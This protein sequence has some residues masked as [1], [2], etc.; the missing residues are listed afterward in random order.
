MKLK[1]TWILYWFGILLCAAIIVRV[2]TNPNCPVSVAI[3]MTLLYGGVSVF[4]IY[5][6]FY[7]GK[8]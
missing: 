1:T 3:A 2:W 5:N 4:S 7:K 6:L 8:I